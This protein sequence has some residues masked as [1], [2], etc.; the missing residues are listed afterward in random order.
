MKQPLKVICGALNRQGEKCKKPPMRGKN[1]CQLHGGKTPKSQNAGKANNQHKHGLYSA[2]LSPAEAEQW[3]DISLDSLDDEIRMTRIWLAR[4]GALDLEVSKDPNSTAHLA[5]F[6]LSEI[7]KTTKGGGK[8]DTSI[9]F[10]RPDLWGRKDRLLGRLAHLVKTRAELIAQAQASGEGVGD[11]A[12][13]L[14]ETLRDMVDLERTPPEPTQ[15][16]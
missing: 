16:E 12:R 7:T 5:G 14:V 10:K 8:G 6:E 3:D 2:S 15:D 11:V 13:D 1:R 9:V 4:A